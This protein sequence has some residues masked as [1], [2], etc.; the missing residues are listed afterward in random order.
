MAS[1]VEG[2]RRGRPP[3]NLAAYETN[4]AINTEEKV[5]KG[6]TRWNTK[7]KELE[8][9]LQNLTENLAKKEIELNS[10]SQV[11]IELSA[12]VSKLEVCANLLY[13][14]QCWF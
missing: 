4:L 8:F 1:G 12:S 2:K 13:I 6:G 10:Q 5:S 3:K 7:K 14:S 11:N 9:E